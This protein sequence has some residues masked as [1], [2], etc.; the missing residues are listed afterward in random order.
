MARGGR[1]CGTLGTEHMGMAW[2]EEERPFLRLLKLILTEWPMKGE[3]A[4]RL[5]V[6]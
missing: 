2:K 3:S 5:E 4:I 6:I 1:A